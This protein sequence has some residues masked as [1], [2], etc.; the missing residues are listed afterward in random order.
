LFRTIKILFLLL[1]AFNPTLLFGA[2]QDSLQSVKKIIR[3]SPV[4][5]LREDIE[6]ILDNSDLANAVCGIFVRS[7]KTGE[8]IF[9]T[10]ESKNLIPASLTKLFTTSAALNILNPDFRYSTKLYLDGT[11]SK[12]GVFTG[13]IIIR[14]SGDPTMSEKFGTDV[15]SLFKSWVDVLDSLDIKEING[16]IICDDRYLDGQFYAPGWSVD[17]LIYPF[18]APVDAIAVFDNQIKITLSSGDSAGMP[19]TISIEPHNNFIE[20][21]NNIIT[22]A[23]DKPEEIYATRYKDYNIIELF[24]GLPYDSLHKNKS[25]IEIAINDPVSF[26]LGLFKET[27]KQNDFK[28]KGALL[29]YAAAGYDIDYP[30]MTPVAQYLSP[31]L[32]KIT[33]NINKTSNNLAAEMLLKTIGKEGTGDGSFATGCNMVKKY[34]KRIGIP[35][36]NI[37]LYDGSGL[38]RYNLLQ[39]K[40]IVDLLFKIYMSEFRNMFIGTLACPGKEGTLKRRMTNSQAEE[41][42]F[43]KTGSMNNVTN[44]A[45]YVIT[46]DGEYLA[47]AIMVMNHNVPET[48]V[49]NIQDLI[50]MRLATFSR[51]E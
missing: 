27:L 4:T 3:K 50:C 8:T 29:D 9:K 44:L 5:I 12:K 45:G 7:C 10:N 11:K 21:H 13:N 25:E 51:K 16:N 15:E 33:E 41:R 26:F 40:Y 38:S 46:A 31:Q 23:D 32:I 19:V 28:F 47:F 34:C 18:A 22:L 6:S 49:Q 17:D 48:L 30:S 14:A 24:G 36:K 2:G 35:L 20:I 37:M 39:P 42:V 43:A 1:L